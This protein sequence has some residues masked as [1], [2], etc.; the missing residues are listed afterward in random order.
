M[1]D[2]FSP[3]HLVDHAVGRRPLLVLLMGV[4]ALLIFYADVRYGDMAMTGWVVVGAL[5]G[6]GGGMLGVCTAVSGQ[7]IDGHRYRVPLSRHGL[8]SYDPTCCR[9]CT[10]DAG[11]ALLALI[12]SLLAAAMLGAAFLGLVGLL[13]SM[14]HHFEINHG[15]E[16]VANA[17]EHEFSLILTLTSIVMGS[18]SATRHHYKSRTG[19]WKA[20]DNLMDGDPDTDLH[21]LL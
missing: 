4:V 9:E 13:L 6:A 15:W 2:G 11:M 1:R 7:I 14:L 19:W 21:A 20:G 8:G 10:K 18:Y 5:S 3:A 12:L 17:T 16:T